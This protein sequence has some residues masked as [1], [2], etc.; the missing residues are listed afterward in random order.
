MEK[1]TKTILGLGVAVVGGYLLYKYWQGQQ[2]MAT[3]VAAAPASTTTGTAS[4]TASAVPF[5]GVEGKN[6]FAAG[7][8][9]IQSSGWVRNAD[10]GG[11][12]KEVSGR[13]FDVKGTSW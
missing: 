13:F 7:N 5:V 3:P 1:R 9:N 6:S 12:P 11:S 8:S 4:S 10:G 2:P